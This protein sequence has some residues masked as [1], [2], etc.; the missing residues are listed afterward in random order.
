MNL[1]KKLPILN[2][3]SKVGRSLGIL[4]L[5]FSL[6]LSLFIAA[7]IGLSMKNGLDST[8]ARLGADIVVMPVD[9]Q[10]SMEGALLSG[11]PN[12]FYL[13][14]DITDR[15][16]AVEGVKKTSPQVY[17]ASLGASC[18]SFPVQVIGI[19][20]DTD[21]SVTPWMKDK[22]DGLESGEI[23]V[24]ANIVTE[25][26]GTI[27]LF[28]QDLTVK[29]NLD[30][31]GM[32][33][34]NSVF[35]SI[36]DARALAE[37]AEEQGVVY[38]VDQKDLVSNVMVE[39]ED[40]IRPDMVSYEINKII[41]GEARATITDTIISSLGTQ[42]SSSA[43]YII[44]LLGIIWVLCIVVLL[45][46]FPMITKARTGEF[47]TLRVLGAT[48]KD[49]SSLLLKEMAIL[50]VAGSIIGVVLGFVL[51]NSFATAIK[52]SLDVPF[53]TPDLPIQIVVIVLAIVVCSLI[54]PISSLITINKLNK[55]EIAVVYGKE[56]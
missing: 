1:F 52:N 36:E 45:I 14:S 8:E 26:G 44:L 24:G 16:R 29:E 55:E 10:G 17:I 54:G 39:V 27:M 13:S 37:S 53:L 19:D 12:S 50:S 51:S 43:N 46:V 18:C 25:K 42:M 22:I 9:A 11:T 4:G 31:T 32:G 38:P 47:A 56:G 6:A 33:F 41:K 7:F 34:D 5:V 23:L 49:I 40:G 2:I 30:K 28:N 48:K 35:M 20:F 15:I 3:K 21:F